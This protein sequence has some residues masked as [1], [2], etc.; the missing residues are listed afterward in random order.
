MKSAIRKLLVVPLLFMALPA[1]AAEKI[2]YLTFDD[3][4]LS[5]TANILQV[6]A[7]ERVLAT[8]FMV[9][10]HADASK[11]RTAL[12]AMAKSMPLLTVGNHSYTHANNHYR[13]FYSSVE[14]LLADL[15]RANKSLGLKGP[16][17]YTRLPGRNVFRFPDMS[18]DDFSIGKPEDRREEPGF[19]FVAASGYYYMAGITNG[20]TT[21]K[22]NPSRRSST[23]S[24][25]SI[26][27]LLMENWRNRTS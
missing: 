17:I 27:S 20:S 7:K 13:Y 4:P 1:A 2:I 25:K 11:D 24:A 12:V 21:I 9:G 26:T 19:E 15:A 23:W 8:M 22:A 18:S 6:L 16:P 3:G 5:G 14:G 10:M